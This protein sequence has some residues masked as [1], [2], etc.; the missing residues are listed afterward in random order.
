[1]YKHLSLP[2]CPN[3]FFYYQMR[4]MPKKYQS[5]ALGSHTRSVS[6]HSLLR[7]ILVMTLT[8]VTARVQ[9]LARNPPPGLAWTTTKTRTQLD[10]ANEHQPGQ[11]ARLCL[12]NPNSTLDGT[13]KH[14]LSSPSKRP[15]LH[16]LLCS[17]VHFALWQLKHMVSCRC[18]QRNISTAV[19]ERP[20][21]W[22]R[23]GKGGAN[24]LELEQQRK[25]ER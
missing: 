3:F 11:S 23:S 22:S 14:L 4:W 12:V 1:M 20:V 2:L 13:D 16:A 6:S 18:T 25:W 19:V 5:N 7:Y 21:V 15:P 8:P 10:G 24:A 9:A 17:I